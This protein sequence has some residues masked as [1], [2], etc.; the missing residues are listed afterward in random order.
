MNAVVQ[1]SDGFMW[2]G[3]YGGLVR[4]DG[5][6]FLHF[7]ASSGITGVVSLYV[8]SRDRLWVGTND[9]GVALYDNG[10]FRFY[11]ADS[12]IRSLS[13]RSI[14]EDYAG[15]IILG[16]TEGISYIDVNGKL[17]NL[18][19]EHIYGEYVIELE[20][21]S[22]GNVYGV[23]QSGDFFRISELAID[24]LWVNGSVPGGTVWCVCPVPNQRGYVYLGTESANIV[25]LNTDNPD[26]Y[27][28]YSVSPNTGVNAVRVINDMVW[29]CTDNGI[30]YFDKFNRYHSVSNVPMND[31]VGGIMQDFEGNLWFTSKRQGLME[32]TVTPFF[33]ISVAA[34]L[35]SMVVNTTC[36]FDHDL[37]IG[38]DNG[39][40]VLDS[41]YRKVENELTRM[42]EGVRVRCI[43]K[44]GSSH[45][46]IC[47]YGNTGLISYKK[48]GTITVYNKDSGL[49]SNKVRDIE[50]LYDGTVAVAENG[51]LDIIKYDNVELSYSGEQGLENTE[52][53]TV[54]EGDGG[55]IYIGTDGGGIYVIDGDVVKH[56][57]R[58]DG[59]GSDIILR[60]K[61]DEARGIYWIITSNSIGYMKDEKITTLKNFPYSNNFDI[62]LD[63]SNRA[64]ILSSSGIYIVNA[65]QLLSGDNVEYLF[66]GSESVPYITTAN[67]RSFL[68]DDGT[69]YIACSSGVC[70]INI[71]GDIVNNHDV[72]LA[73]PYV[74]IDDR[75]VYVSDGEKIRIPAQSKRITIYGYA[76][77]YMLNK[78]R[79]T[80]Q[81]KGFDN[82]TVSISGDALIPVSYTNLGYGD[83]KFELSVIDPMTNRPEQTISVVFFKERAFYQRLWFWIAVA[84]V[85]MGIGIGAAMINVHRKAVRYREREKQNETFTNQVIRA[86]AK[87]I[88]LNDKYTK[89]HSSRVADYS[90]M[91]AQKMGYSENETKSYL[92]YC[93]AP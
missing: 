50:F 79:L 25:R 72:R 49:I 51:G 24:E 31:S 10:E 21:D 19:D 56:L 91:L 88:E 70:S 17:H 46:W 30:G 6:V 15:N 27:K 80:Y 89:G 65:D 45:L 35:D 93:H 54:C 23:T 86:F 7:D 84:A 59:L 4:Y 64:W 16:T 48:N 11:G 66:Y 52:V 41:G 69:L 39:L 8:D 34:G 38:T 90:K 47:T 63:N 5:N 76:I 55:K 57:G 14:T 73:I 43:K 32:I 26:D 20:N 71:N 74:D 67:S 53:L 37:Y 36:I 29:V 44:Q 18:E 82:D 68:G 81:L 9:S 83:Y 42:L 40:V 12:G 22:E 85:I 2:I 60:I 13:V 75:R 58:Q 28:I 61:K 62:Y 78:P 3:S 77:S 33:D 87:T 1:T 92:Q